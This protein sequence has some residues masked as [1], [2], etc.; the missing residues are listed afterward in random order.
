M[1]KIETLPTFDIDLTAAVSKLESLITTYKAKV[2]EISDQNEPPTWETFHPL[3][4]LDDEYHNFISPISHLVGVKDSDELREVWEQMLPIMSDFGTWIGQHKR[5]S[6]KV[7]YLKLC[8]LL[9]PDQQKVADNSWLSFEL[10][11]I[12]L[13]EDEQKRFAEISRELSEL[14]NQFNKNDLDATKAWT[15]HT[16]DE[17]ELDGVP[18]TALAMYAQSAK[19]RD[20]KGYL[21]TLDHPSTNPLMLYCNNR[22][23]REKVSKAAAMKASLLS[24]YPEFDNTENINKQMKLRFEQSALLGRNNP[25]EISLVKKMADT[26]EQVAEF[27]FDMAE[28]AYP[29]A[30]VDEKALRQ[31]AKDKG[32]EDFQ[33]WDRS[34]YSEIMEEEIYNINNNEIKKYFQL[35]NV[36]NGL[37]E[38]VQTLYGIEVREEPND[39]VWVDDVRFFRLYRGDAH[40]ASIYM[41]LYTAPDRKRSGAWMD[42]PIIRWRKEDGTVQLPVAYNVCNFTPPTD[43]TPSLLSFRDVETIFHEFGHALHHMLTVVDIYDI[44]GI[45]G[46]EWDAVELPSQI[47]ENWCWSKEVVDNISEHYQTGEKMP[48]EMFDNMLAA[49]NF[50]SG[51]AILGQLTMSLFD[52]LLHMNY[53]PDEE[54]GIR[55]ILMKV[56]AKVSVYETPYYNRFEN[57]FSHIF[58]GSY[59][60]GYYSYI[61][62]QILADDCFSKFEEEGI[63]NPKVA[64]NFR[65][66]ILSQ[67]GTKSMKELFYNFMG[68]EPSPDAMLKNRGIL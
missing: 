58:A 7:H 25:A 29:K 46:V 40:F 52:M 57:T 2:E 11:G 68:R 41:D 61:W 42:E 28:K 47:M 15:Y 20:L 67:G 37:F 31:F 18:E 54:N 49:K 1:T 59:N 44:S 9:T 39:D 55:D 35:D 23:L 13:P 62:A 30:K 64:E 19:N 27:L 38:L 56:R 12:D 24:E 21:V 32:C 26:P 45:N 60:A 50:M 5:F 33:V 6:E 17:S 3:T 51:H 34:Y 53:N 14:S 10:S 36:L 63:F 8:G 43:T 4:V 66:E 65:K 16:E 48:D 22:E